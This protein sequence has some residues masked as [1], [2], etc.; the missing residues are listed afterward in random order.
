MCQ[1]CQLMMLVMTI[2]L[3]FLVALLMPAS[4]NLKAGWVR[5]K[6]NKLHASRTPFNV[7]LLHNICNTSSNNSQKEHCGFSR[8]VGGKNETTCSLMPM[9]FRTIRREPSLKAPEQVTTWPWP[10][11]SRSTTHKSTMGP[12]FTKLSKTSTYEPLASAWEFSLISCRT[13]R[14]CEKVNAASHSQN[15]WKDHLGK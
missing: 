15:K 7:K 1:M 12:K 10:W 2:C 9:P 14:K 5:L 11:R 6:Q 4:T 3:W 8:T 13:E